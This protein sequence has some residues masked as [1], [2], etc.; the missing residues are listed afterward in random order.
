MRSNLI[1][2]VAWIVL[3]LGA[4]KGVFMLRTFIHYE[5]DKAFGLVK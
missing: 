4:I 3:S 2:V 1:L 5:V